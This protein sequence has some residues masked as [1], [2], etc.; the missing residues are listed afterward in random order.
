MQTLW[1][2]LKNKLSHIAPKIVEGLHQGVTGAQIK[3]LE[4]KL[5]VKLPKD[6]I[7]FYKVH[8]GQNEATPWMVD[9]EELLSFDRI[10]QEWR[11][12]KDLLDDKH[13]EE[14]DGKQYSSEPENGIK[15]LWWN[16][17]WIP[18]TYDGAGNHLCLDLDPDVDGNYGQTIRMWHDDSIRT[19]NG[20]SFT[21]WITNYNTQL[22]NDDLVYAED[23][24]AIINK[25]DV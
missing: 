9:G 16:D 6:F 23:N 10:Y 22:Q 15:N 1:D 18:F 13:F 5:N 17:Q 3:E 25:N 2:Q 20:K 7:A 19:L 11:V 8:N 21:Q 14:S 4:E 12:W 24:S